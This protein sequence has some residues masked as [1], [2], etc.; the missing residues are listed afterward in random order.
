M[1]GESGPPDFDL[2]FLPQFFN[3]PGDEITPGSDIIG[4]YFQS[5]WFGHVTS[6]FVLGLVFERNKYSWSNG[7]LEYWSNGVMGIKLAINYG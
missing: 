3:T 4:K 7:V 1:Q 5:S 2:E 6:P